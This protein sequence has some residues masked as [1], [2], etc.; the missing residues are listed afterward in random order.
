MKNVRNTQNPDFFG[1]KKA[2]M[3]NSPDSILDSSKTVRLKLGIAHQGP[4]SLD[5]FVLSVQLRLNPK[6]T[7]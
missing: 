3:T 7:E 1:F 6:F 5:K 4:L 2:Q